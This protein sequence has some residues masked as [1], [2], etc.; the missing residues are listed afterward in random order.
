MRLLIITVLTSLSLST[1][2]QE[3]YITSLDNFKL[4]EK[5]GLLLIPLSEMNQDPVAVQMSSAERDKLAHLIHKTKNVCGGYLAV[6]TD[7]ESEMLDHSLNQVF[8]FSQLPYFDLKVPQ[9]QNQVQSAISNTSSAPLR[10]T[11]ACSSP[12]L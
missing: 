3:N 2:A 5:N 7:F 6:D 12:K 10:L 1:L 9:A 8:N 4:A 11:E